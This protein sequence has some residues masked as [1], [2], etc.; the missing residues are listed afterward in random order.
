MIFISTIEVSSSNSLNKIYRPIE[1]NDA[2]YKYFTLHTGQVYPNIADND[3]IDDP[4]KLAIWI[5]PDSVDKVSDLDNRIRTFP[6][7]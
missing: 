1:F 6:C 2:F 3:N 5:N 7:R 4:S